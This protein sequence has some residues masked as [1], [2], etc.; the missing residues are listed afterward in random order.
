MATVRVMFMTANLYRTAYHK[1]DNSSSDVRHGKEGIMI[2][3]K[4]V[5]TFYTY[6]YLISMETVEE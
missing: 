2:Y 1:V 5:T 3:G 4:G 6:R